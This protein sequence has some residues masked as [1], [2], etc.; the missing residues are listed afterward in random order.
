[1]IRANIS[2]ILISDDLQKRKY[3]KSLETS[4]IC[5]VLENL[6]PNINDGIKYKENPRLGQMCTL[7][8]PN[9]KTMKIR[10]SLLT[11]QGT[12]LFNILPKTIRNMKNVP[13]EKI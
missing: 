5:K 8:I 3:S 1:M 12:G 10:E 4:H 6:V 2:D 11:F 13:I 9:P 7:S